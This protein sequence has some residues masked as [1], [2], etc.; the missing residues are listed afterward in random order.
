MRQP[1]ASMRDRERGDESAMDSTTALYEPGPLTPDVTSTPIGGPRKNM[2]KACVVLAAV[3]ASACAARPHAA[4][5]AARRGTDRA[6]VHLLNRVTFGAR[7]EDIDRVR[8]MGIAAYIER[9]LHPELIADA[10]IDGRVAALDGLRVSPRTFFTDYYQPMTV[11]RQELSAAQKPSAAGTRP[12]FVRWH[13]LPVAAMSLPGGDRAVNI[14]Q[15]AEVT[16]EELRFQRENQRVFDALQAQKLLRAVY[17]ERQLQ[18]VLTD[19]WFN[20]FNVDARKIEDRPVMVAYERDVIRPHAL[21]RFRDLLEATAS[22]SAMLFYLDNWLSAAPQKRA[23]GRGVNENY[24]RE[25]LEL[26]TLG[27]DGGY[28]QRDVT[29]VARCFTGWTM[30]NP[31]DGLGFAFK[32]AMHD[33]GEKRVLGHRIR[34]GR[35]IEDGEQVLDILAR[36]PSTA[37]F[38]AAKLVRRFVADDP[39]ASLVARAA[40]TFRRTGG[41]IRE[42]VRTILMSPEFQRQSVYD[43]KVRSPFEFVVAS[44]RATGADVQRPTPFVGTIANLGE[45]M[46]QSQPPTGY[47][48]RGSAWISTGAL[49]GRLNFAFA[50]AANGLNAAVVDR[51]IAEAHLRRVLPGLGPNPANGVPAMRVA[52]LLGS[53]DF[54]HR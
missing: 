25:L 41:D 35:G 47:P 26:H 16:P 44:L 17:S 51:A 49:V 54:Q 23:P 6:I 33:A 52:A 45:P 46:Y 8:V 12:P 18:E 39:P 53:P 29:E 24:G 34:A 48:D 5:T 19:F 10:A 40:G 20:H 21:G 36:H 1:A 22:S 28:T 13:L 37:K 32:P 27:V 3:A 30:A 4:Q 2:V 9:Q 31:H 11:A 38:V 42:V 7:A 50:L 15:Q 14:L 43:A